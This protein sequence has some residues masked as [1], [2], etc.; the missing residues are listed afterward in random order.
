MERR[1][2]DSLDRAIEQGFEDDAHDARLKEE[3]MTKIK[4]RMSLLGSLDLYGAESGDE[5]SFAFGEGVFIDK[6]QKLLSRASTT[7]GYA[8]PIKPIITEYT[9]Y[10]VDETGLKEGIWGIMLPNN[11]WRALWDVFVAVFVIYLSWKVPMDVCFPIDFFTSSPSK[12]F[13]YFLEGFFVIDIYLNFRTGYVHGSHIITDPAKIRHHYTH[14][15][16]PLDVIASVPFEHIFSESV[17]GKLFAGGR[18]GVCVRC[19]HSCRPV[20]L[21]LCDDSPTEV[22]AG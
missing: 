8:R 10:E 7:H 19:A 21:H 5:G 4:D 16:F 1:P 15:W 14:G 20:R 11:K 3:E 9:I 13:D 6:G 22:R 17:F 18:V 2:S 12:S